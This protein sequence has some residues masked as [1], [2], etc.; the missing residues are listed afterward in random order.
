MFYK[1]QTNFPKTK[2]LE[3]GLEDFSKGLNFSKEEN[4]LNTDYS[5]NNYNFAYKKGVLT[6]NYGFETLTCPNYMNDD[7]AEVYFG[8]DYVVNFKTLWFFKVYDE[9]NGGR[10]D[11]LCYYADDK[12]LYYSRVMT[13]AP[14]IARAYQ[15][16]YEEQP[17]FFYNI[18]L[19]NV[20]YNL[21]G[22]EN[23]GVYKFDGAV[24]P[25]LMHNFPNLSSMCE[26][27]GKLFGTTYGEKNIV[28]YHTDLD[29]TT[30]TKES[31]ESNGKIVMNDDRGKI[32]K[33]IPFLGYVFAIRDYGI[34]KIINYAN[35][36]N[37]DITHLSLSGNKI[38]ENTVL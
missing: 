22:S 2:S 17:T 16:E 11:K 26:D 7:F 28:Y 9:E 21:F 12:G 4:I 27:K 35:K 3:I 13:R 1:K 24:A 10:V 6:E 30:W 38:Y 34:T 33:V 31:D 20:D 18:K 36:V 19:N 37:F 25:V 8:Y 32:N 23:M 5:V 14:I 29:F 15:L